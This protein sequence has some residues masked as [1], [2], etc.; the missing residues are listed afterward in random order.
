MLLMQSLENTAILEREI[1]RKKL[2]E[3]A[4]SLLNAEHCERQMAMHETGHRQHLRAADVKAFTLGMSTTNEQD[5]EQLQAKGI[6]DSIALS[7]QSVSRAAVLET[8]H[9][10]DIIMSARPRGLDLNLSDNYAR[11][12]PGLIPIIGSQQ[13]PGGSKATSLIASRQLGKEDEA[14]R[15][16]AAIRVRFSTDCH[17]TDDTSRDR[18]NTIAFVD[19]TS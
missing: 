15:T 17:A 3:A 12:M 2:T 5:F 10:R 18:T 13:P 14:E 11:I 6:F 19:N 9:A 7:R 8:K 16:A 4:E 1:A